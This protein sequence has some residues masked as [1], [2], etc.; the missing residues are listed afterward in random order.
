MHYTFVKGDTS[1]LPSKVVKSS[2]FGCRGVSG[3]QF[4]NRN[5][6]E[7]RRQS[8]FYLGIWTVTAKKKI[9]KIRKIR[10]PGV[11]KWRRL[12]CGNL[13]MTATATNNERPVP[14]QSYLGTYRYSLSP[15]ITVMG[16]L[17]LSE[18]PETG[19]NRREKNQE[20]YDLIRE[21]QPLSPAECMTV[22]DRLG[23]CDYVTLVRSA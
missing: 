22:S 4:R 15:V 21:I 1:N 13:T 20:I 16:T 11:T 17:D 19:D 12:K 18:K 8:K 9:K 7:S 5:I 6:W 10:K 2:I 14:M 3:P 23:S